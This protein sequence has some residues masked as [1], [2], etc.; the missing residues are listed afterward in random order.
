MTALEPPDLTIAPS[1]CRTASGVFPR[2]VR[3]GGRLAFL[4]PGSCCDTSAATQIGVDVRSVGLDESRLRPWQRQ[5]LATYEEAGP[6][7]DFLLT[8]TPGA[9]KTTFALAVAGRLLA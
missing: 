2:P 4:G 3:S 8:A 7:R 6:R 5:T 1:A 9:G